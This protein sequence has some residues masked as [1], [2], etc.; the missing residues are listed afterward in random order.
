MNGLLVIDKPAGLTSHDVI[1]RVRHTLHERRVRS[2]RNTRSFCDRRIA[3]SCWTFDATCSILFG[4][5]DKQYEAIIRLGYATTT[6]DRTG[7]PFPR[8]VNQLC[9]WTENEIESAMAA[10]RGNIDQ[11]PPMY[12]AKKLQVKS[13]MN[14]RRRGEEVERQPVKVCIHEFVALRPEGQLMKDNV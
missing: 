10:L 1:S 3:C 13:S 7:D 9:I 6:G 8:R 4:A 5:D 12:S 14:S 2:Y 11:V